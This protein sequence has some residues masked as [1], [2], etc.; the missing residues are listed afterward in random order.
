MFRLLVPVI[1]T[2]SVFLTSGK[3][4]NET[5]TPKFYFVLVFV[6]AAI[7]FITLTQKRLTFYV[8]KSKT[9]LWGINIICFLQACYGILQFVGWFSSNHSQFA[10]TG[11]FDNPAGFATVLSVGFPVG[12]FLF[13]KSGQIGKYFAAVILIAIAMA[14]FL[15]GSRTGILAIIISSVV[16]FLSGSNRINVFRQLSHYR[17]ITALGIGCLAVSVFILYHQKKDSANGRLLIW[18]VSSE[19]IKDRPLLGH[20]YGAFKAKYMDYQA[21]YFKNN[22]GSDY[23]LLADNVRH[24]FNEFIKVAVEFG[25]AGL[26]VVLFLILFVL[27]KIIESGK[28][29]RGLVLS[30]IV[31]FLVFAC[32]SY[33]LQYVAVWLLLVFYITIS[34]PRK[35]IKIEK[36][37]I[38]II[39]RSTI[40]I[41]CLAS[42]FYVYQQM[43]AEIKWKEIA[44]NSLRG[45]TEEMLPEYEKLYSTSLKQNPFF[46]YNYGAEL[47]VAGKFDKSLAVFDLC[48]RYFNDIDVQM[49]LANNCRG[50]GKHGDAER[51]LKTAAAMCPV[52]FM[53]LYELAKLYEATGRHEKAIALA[54][55]ILD[56]KVKVPSPTVNAVKNEMRQLIEAEAQEPADS[57]PAAESRTS[58]KTGNRKQ[59]GPSD[60][61]DS[62]E[63]PRP[64]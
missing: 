14:V 13:T 37:P 57:I 4:V 40:V 58:E 8:T 48:M 60:F 27:L 41:G 26:L 53:P 25:I 50:L 51:H 9:I 35:E 18:R 47:N 6:L 49:L 42:L 34:F 29:D 32:F 43:R 10:V 31:S 19:M 24:P 64:P 22:P 20:G 2:G 56:K 59:P 30:G 11:S 36:T 63:A 44:I 21:E 55:K 33:P 54:K 28:E 61:S 5:N 15:S 17:L 1:F 38:S 39:A 52:R 7:V 23:A 62:S 3:F 46:L 16:F 45:R 12:V